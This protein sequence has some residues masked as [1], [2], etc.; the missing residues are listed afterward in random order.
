MKQKIHSTASMME[1]HC[2]N[3][4]WPIIH[5]CCNDEMS[6]FS[7]SESGDI[8]DYWIYCSNKGCKN[9]T[10]SETDQC[11]WPSWVESNKRVIND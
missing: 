6:D 4:G 1:A 8:Q 2:V 7:E 3:C 9:H 5:A 10:G 11:G